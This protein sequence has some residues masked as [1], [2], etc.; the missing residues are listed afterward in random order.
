[1][2]SIPVPTNGARACSSG[3]PCR[4][5]FDPINARLASSCSRKGMRDAATETSCFGDTSMNSTLSR[6]ARM[7]S[8]AFLA[9]TRESIRLP[10]SSRRAFA[11]AMMYRSSSHAER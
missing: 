2:Y 8:P 9:L 10:P 6:G 4:C 5:M 1:M 3:T 11:C 7:N